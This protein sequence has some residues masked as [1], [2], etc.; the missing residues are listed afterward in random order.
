M[1]LVPLSKVVGVGMVELLL[2]KNDVGTD[3]GGGGCSPWLKSREQVLLPRPR[4]GVAM[5]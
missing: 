5:T 2:L 4:V 3:V 1:M